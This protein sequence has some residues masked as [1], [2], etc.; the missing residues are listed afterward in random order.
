L[1]FLEELLT[2]RRGAAEKYNP[3]KLVMAGL[4]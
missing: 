1:S 3:K 2:R 4:P